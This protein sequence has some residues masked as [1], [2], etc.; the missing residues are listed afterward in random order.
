MYSLVI[1]GRTQEGHAHKRA[2]SASGGHGAVPAKEIKKHLLHGLL[3]EPQGWKKR[4]SAILRSFGIIPV[5]K[6]WFE[7]YCS[8][9]W[10][11]LILPE[12]HEIYTDLLL[13]SSFNLLAMS[14]ALLK[15]SFR[16]CF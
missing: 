2:D 7:C 6:V 14:S 9:R 5:R 11:Y 3:L 4:A 16:K 1:N 12:N 8:S 13:F 15:L 10:L